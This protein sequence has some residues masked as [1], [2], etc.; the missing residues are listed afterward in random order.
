M[1]SGIGG[2]VYQSQCNEITRSWILIQ[3]LGAEV[4]EIICPS[5]LSKRQLFIL[6][7]LGLWL[8]LLHDGEFTA[9]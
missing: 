1:S 3:F 7:S 6:C 2:G 8:K 4:L 5:L 9:I